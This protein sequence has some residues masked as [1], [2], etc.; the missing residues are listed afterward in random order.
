MGTKDISVVVTTFNRDQ[1][2]DEALMSLAAQTIKLDQVVVVD[3]G[4][5]GTAKQVVDKYGPSFQYFWQPNGGKQR[6]R[7]F[8]ISKTQ[9][10]WIA[11]HDDD[12]IWELNRC[13]ILRSV[14]VNDSVDLIVS[15]FLIFNETG[16]HTLSFFDHHAQHLP[17]FW[18]KIKRNEGEVY[19]VIDQL[20]P[21]ELFPEYAFWG[22]MTIISKNTLVNIGGWDESLKG[23]CSE[24]LDF[25][26]RAIRNSRIA[27]IWEPTVRYRSHPGNVSNDGTEKLLGRVEIAKRLIKKKMIYGAEI[28]SINLFIQKAQ[29]E[30]HWSYFNKRNYQKVLEISK[31]IGWSNINFQ[32][33]AKTAYS[34]IMQKSR[35]IL[36]N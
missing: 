2:L 32:S 12:D 9:G 14:I 10:H 13:E 5:P 23:V 7:N 3:D 31:Q 22:A 33:K 28:R 27:L 6:A 36:W 18:K 15:N 29:E 24:D 8:G 35:G 34:Y 21:I 26:F 1:F 20:S 30:A 16:I 4:G 25:I 11:F 17:D 19:T